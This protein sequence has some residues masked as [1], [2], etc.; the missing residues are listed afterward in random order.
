MNIPLQEGRIFRDEG[1]TELVAVVSANAASIL[2]PNQNPIGRKLHHW[3]AEKSNW[4][5]VVGVVGDVRSRGLDQDPPPTVYRPFSQRAY[6]AFSIILRTQRDPEEMRA[7]LRDHLWNVDSEV[8][9]P[10]IRSMTQLVSQSMAARRMQAI[11][12]AVFAA[13]AM[14]LAAIGVYGVVAYSVVKRRREIAVRIALGATG[15]DINPLSSGTVCCRFW[16]GSPLE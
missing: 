5:R 9:V 16:S 10:A 11:L 2:W 3:Y 13:V 14:L 6:P 8:P 7:V 4:V 15:S 12:T 1:E